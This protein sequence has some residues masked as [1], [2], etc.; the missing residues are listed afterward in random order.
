MSRFIIIK[1]TLSNLTDTIDVFKTLVG[2]NIEI[3]ENNG[4][5]IIKYN[6]DNQND[7][8]DLL[9][10][11]SNENMF[12]LTCYISSLHEVALDEE[13][14]IGLALIDQLSSGFYSLKKALLHV[15]SI[16]NAKQILDTILNSTGIDE[17]FI[18]QFVS[19]DLN[20]SKAS[21]GM[22]LHR[23]T[24]N[25]KLDKLLELTGFDLRVFIDSYILFNLIKNK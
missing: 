2:Q 9:V 12:D 15:R 5:T 24:L 22:Y 3:T 6:Y 25:Y 14:N 10:S 4:N 23:N 13:L 16:N 8:Y 20:I 11:F 7:V 19:N 1:N 21:K 17:D 18:K